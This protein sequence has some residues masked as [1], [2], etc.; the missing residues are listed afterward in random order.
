MSKSKK[1]STL[2]LSDALLRIRLSTLDFRE[3]DKL[4]KKYPDFKGR[5][6][7]KIEEERIWGTH[8]SKLKTRAWM[9][10]HNSHL[11]YPDATEKNGK[12]LVFVKFEELDS[13][14]QKVK[15]ALDAGSLG[16]SMKSSTGLSNRGVMA[17]I[18][19][20][21]YN[22]DDVEDVKRVRKVLREIGI[23]WKIPYKTDEDT[24]MGRYSKNGDT[25]ISLY[26]E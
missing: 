9:D 23:T 18:I 2:S 7:E 8:P 12:W 1:T 6:L 20:Y 24:L 21:T 11:N 14:F 26:F 19:V 15:A 25:R 16:K 5:F 10:A 22:Y 4:F 3:L 17:V 13:W